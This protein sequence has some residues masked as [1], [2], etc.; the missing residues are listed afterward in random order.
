MLDNFPNPFNPVT[1][2]VY[3]SP[4]ATHVRITVYNTAGM[5]VATVIDAE[6]PAGYWTTQW[7]ASDVATGMYFYTVELGDLKTTRRLVILK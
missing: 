7:N 2:F 4:V 5:K 1:T 6:V 3:G